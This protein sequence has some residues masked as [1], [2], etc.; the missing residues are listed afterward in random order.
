MNSAYTSRGG[1]DPLTASKHN[2]KVRTQ[3]SLQIY[4][5]KLFFK[6]T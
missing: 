6:M 5:Q 4:F 3:K 1:K 2:Y